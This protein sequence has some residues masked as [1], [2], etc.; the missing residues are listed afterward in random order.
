VK[1]GEIPFS[2]FFE[3]LDNK[4]GSKDGFYS[5]RDGTGTIVGASRVAVHNVVVGIREVEVE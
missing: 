4:D 3:W 1:E 5:F 2:H